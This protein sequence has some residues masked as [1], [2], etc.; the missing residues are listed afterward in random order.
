MSRILG[1][2]V[3]AVASTGHPASVVGIPAAPAPPTLVAS[4]T[5]LVVLLIFLRG[6]PRG[7]SS[8]S[9]RSSS[10]AI[11]DGDL[12]NYPVWISEMARKPGVAA[13][14]DEGRLKR[15]LEPRY[16][17]Q[18]D[19]CRE[20]VFLSWDSKSILQFVD[21]ERR[22]PRPPGWEGVYKPSCWAL[23]VVSPAWADQ[24]QG[25]ANAAS[26]T[27]RSAGADTGQ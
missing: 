13:I 26:R 25:D 9:T 8:A 2:D 22:Q 23:S 7:A 4:A 18:I 16:A 24:R 17:S 11:G 20:A 21:R 12:G 3:V 27:W 6:V 19:V 1:H 15:W 14:F 5:V 10:F